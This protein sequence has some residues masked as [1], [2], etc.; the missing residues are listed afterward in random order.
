[1]RLDVGKLAIEQLFGALDRE[2]LD[3]I[4][5][6]AA[7]VVASARITF[8]IFVGENRPLRFKHGLAD[9][10]FRSDELDLRLLTVEF[11]ADCILDRRVPFGNTAGEEAMRHSIIY[12][13]V[14]I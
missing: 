9:D 4:R 7:L 6:R 10:I 5:W 11:R 1:M 8:G 12:V 13:L 3:R 14:E 2:C